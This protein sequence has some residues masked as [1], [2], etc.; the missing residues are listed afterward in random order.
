MTTETG[1]VDVINFLDNLTHPLKKEIQEIRKIILKSNNN[2]TEHIKWNAPS[3]CIDGNDCVTMNFT[4]KS[5][6]LIFHRGAKVKA[7]P[8]QRFISDTTDILTWAAN[9][10]A[11]ATFTTS[12]EIK[13][14]KKDLEVI[15]NKWIKAIKE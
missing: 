10:R 2:L 9:D 6:R 12:E 1:Q 13:T 11:I 5:I 4:P 3:F 7:Q 8:K 14:N 15:V